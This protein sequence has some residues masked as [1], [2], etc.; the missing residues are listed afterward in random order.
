MKLLKIWKRV[1]QLVPYFFNLT[2]AFDT[3]HHTILLKKTPKLWNPWPPLQ[4]FNYLTNRTQYT[5]VNK[6]KSEISLVKCGIP[7]E[8]TLG[9]LL[10]TLYINDLPQ[11]TEF[12][13]KLF[14][15][16]TVLTLLH[17]SHKILNERVNSELNIIDQW[18]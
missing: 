7:Q 6:A 4:L 15:D 2:K 8:S 18:I 9:P 11:T 14:A 5:V 16:D 12:N 10:F 3:V 13:T 17:A 1:K